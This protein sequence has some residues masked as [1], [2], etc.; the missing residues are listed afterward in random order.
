MQRMSL[1]CIRLLLGPGTLHSRGADRMDFTRYS[2]SGNPRMTGDELLATLPEIERIACVEVDDGNPHAVASLEDLRKL[3]VHANELLRRPGLD[4]LVLVQG[5]NQLE[6][7][8]YFLNLTVRSAKPVVI[9]GAQRPYT[10]LSADGPVNLLDAMRVAAA[11]ATRGKGAVVV[12]NGEINAAREV[13][14]TNTYRCTRFAA[15]TWGSSATRTPTQSCTTA[16]RPAGTRWRA[17]SILAP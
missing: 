4:G 5:T 14:K 10:A 11:Q 3:S 1:P 6:E 7:T 12:T 16:R 8:A 2:R 17:S 15:V 9:T 13:T